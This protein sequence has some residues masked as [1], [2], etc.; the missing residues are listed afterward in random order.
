MLKTDLA[1]QEGGKE[2][3]GLVAEWT[4]EDEDQREERVSSEGEARDGWRNNRSGRRGNESLSEE[5]SPISRAF[6]RA[7]QSVFA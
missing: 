7:L 6:L 3:L 5:R 4:S 2:D 1:E